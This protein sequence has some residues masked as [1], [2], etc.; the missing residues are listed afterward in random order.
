MSR[1]LASADGRVMTSTNTGGMETAVPNTTITVDLIESARRSDH[2]PKE[3]SATKVQ[4]AL[5]RYTRFVLLAARHPGLALAPTR[6]IDEMWHLHM[7]S[8]RA[9]YED[10]M[11]LFGE[12]FDHD[13]GFGKDA[14]EVSMLRTTFERTARLWE[15]AYGEPYVDDHAAANATTKCWHDCQSRCWHACKSVGIPAEGSGSA[16]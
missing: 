16:C 3:W 1:F 2:F 7:L 9:Y 13:G 8:P 5:D 6:D 14:S 15:A 12:V 10:C 11:R 4:R